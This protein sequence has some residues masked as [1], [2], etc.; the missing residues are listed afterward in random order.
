MS[1]SR[2]Q[3]ETPAVGQ[4]RTSEGVPATTKQL[5]DVIE[6]KGVGIFN[7]TAKIANL[8]YRIYNACPLKNRGMFCRRKLDEE[9]R[10]DFCAHKAKNPLKNLYV[11]VELRDC[12][13]PESTQTA[14]LFSNTAENFLQLKANEIDQMGQNEPEKLA[15]VFESKLGQQVVVKLNIKESKSDFEGSDFDWIVSRVFTE[16]KANEVEEEEKKKLAEEGE[17]TDDKAADGEIQI[18]GEML[19]GSSEFGIS[20]FE[21]KHPSEDDDDD[22]EEEAG[23]SS[24]QMSQDQS[25]LQLGEG[26]SSREAESEAAAHRQSQNAPLFEQT[27]YHVHKLERFSLSRH[28]TEFVLNASAEEPEE[29]L[30]STF[31]MLIRQAVDNT[32]KQSGRP[33]AK[34]GMSLHGRGLYEP[35]VLP[36]RPLE[37]NTCD[38]LMAELDKL[39]QS[40]GDDAGDDEE[41]SGMD[42]RTLLLSEAVQVTVTCFAPPA[43]AR[44]RH[45]PHQFWGYNEKHRIQICNWDDNYCLFY[46]LI[47][48][49]AYHDPVL[50]KEW[51]Q[52]RQPPQQNMAQLTLLQDFCEG[53]EAFR[54][55]LTNR[56]LMRSSAERLLNAAG[57]R[58]AMN[59]Y[60]IDQLQPIQDY[61]DQRFPGLYRI[62]LFEDRP[63]VLPKPIW[64]GPT[65]RRFDV[66]LF[67]SNGH[68][69]GIKKINCFFKLSRHYCV[70][71]ECTYDKA[72]KHTLECIRRCPQC[73]KIGPEHP[74]AKEPGI[75]IRCASCNRFFFSQRCYDSHRGPTCSLL[76]RCTL[77]RR[78]YQRD[79]KRAHACYTKYCT[80]C[81]VYHGEKTGCFIQKLTIPAEKQRYRIVS[82]DSETRLEPMDCG[83]Q[84]H[85]VNFLSARVSCTECAD[86]R[87]ST[88]C[89]ICMNT[90]GV[91]ERTKHWS[92]AD[93]DEP[94]ADF[95]EWILRAWSDQFKTYIWAHNASRFDGHF[96]LR[97]LGET[98]R[99]PDV[100]MNGLKIFE[101]RLQHSRGNS[102]LTWRDSCLLFP[103][104]L[105]GLK[106]T[107]SLDCADKPFF[108]YGYN[109]REN[110]NIRLENLPD[111]EHYFPGSMKQAKLEKFEQCFWHGCERCYDPNDKL[112]DGRTCRELNESTQDR[113]TQLREPDELGHCMEVE[114]IWECEI[115]SMLSDRRN[116]EMRDFFDDLGNER[117]PIDPRAAYCGGRTGPL[118]LFSEPAEGEK[119]CVYDIVSLYPW[120]NYDAEYP[121]GIPKIIYPSV[122]QIVI[123]WL[124]VVVVVVVVVFVQCTSV[125]RRSSADLLY[126]GLYRVR[127]IPPRGLRI[128]ILPVKLDERLLFCCCHRCAG[129]FRALGTRRHHK[130]THSDEQ[131]AYTGTYTHIELGRALDS[132]YR[133]DRFWRAWHYEEWSDQIFKDYVRLMIKLKE[134]SAIIPLTD[135]V[136]RVSYKQKKNF[137]DEHATSNIVLSLW[138]T[139]CAR[140]KLL[141]Y[142]TQV[143]SADGA[144]LLYTDTDSVI[145]KH[146]F[147]H[148]PIQTGEF[149]GQ[150]SQEY[151]G[152]AISSFVCGG[153]KQYALKMVDERTGECKYVQKIRGITFDVQ[154]SQ[155]LQFEHFKQKVL[156]YG[157]HGERP[158][159]FSYDKIQP[160][161]SS[162]IVTREQL[163]RYL[164][165]CQKG[166]ITENLRV[167]P[168]GFE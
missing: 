72:L 42:K 137:I 138:T 123:D 150:M 22:A 56:A 154:N 121:V 7:V 133:V 164:P 115:N 39:G 57:I 81:K 163:K 101:F 30:R 71:C 23:V 100:V 15:S 34:I 74:C 149:M 140:L 106:N 82:W 92:E 78:V 46:A 70:D 146:R 59:A 168:F 110:Y 2:F 21:Q 55:L 158:A 90:D 31:E 26:P 63:E 80:R 102:L 94:V 105:D 35:I 3:L 167:L 25:R 141:D 132:G 93:G 104:R 166:I 112:V 113:L 108:P 95:V 10:C 144:E 85:K 114:E 89:E 152:F 118:K 62:V 64:K 111:R 37:Q 8:Q 131:R 13:D 97:Y 38:V 27:A 99:R 160:T 73:A 96:I 143:D 24:S 136:I 11:R 77:C 161:K 66:T 33:V 19:P 84:I 52:A 79:P 142:M 51:T 130:C 20:F 117:G 45:F 98:R 65:G 122:E 68:Y 148:V 12:A 126:R 32:Q 159:V 6:F 43:G 155:A 1:L 18:I 103:I 75:K 109:R 134:I 5:K 139:S 120:V 28:V 151:V 162:R 61:W 119:I 47:G 87:P 165:V 60:G 17:L 157:R 116:A 48:S 54:L 40:D 88:H 127:V 41:G 129:K 67:L 53:Q 153:A 83:Q 91:V 135:D 147:D 4:K 128:P 36:L 44:P 125:C 69:D 50:F 76:K 9:M 86:F 29:T 124:V 145:V 156:N 58:E 49:R 14:T 107:F 16:D